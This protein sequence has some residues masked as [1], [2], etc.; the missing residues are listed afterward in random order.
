MD[1]RQ[2]HQAYSVYLQGKLPPTQTEWITQHIQ[3][4]PDCALLDKKVRQ[5][6]LAEAMN[7]PKGSA[8][9]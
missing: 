6:F 7:E 3:D 9:S 8:E 4:C 5:L 2:V 1:C